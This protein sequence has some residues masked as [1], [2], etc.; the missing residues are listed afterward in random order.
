M[1]CGTQVKIMVFPSGAFPLWNPRFEA[2]VDYQCAC[3]SV[4]LSQIF[5]YSHAAQQKLLMVLKAH[6]PVKHECSILEVWKIMHIRPTLA[7]A[8]L[9]ST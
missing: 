9:D 8:P 7:F 4:C 6:T 2:L 3:L 5:S 1:L